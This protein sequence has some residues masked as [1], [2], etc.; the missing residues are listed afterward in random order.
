MLF[1]L[2]SQHFGAFAAEVQDQVAVLSRPFVSGVLADAVERAETS[3]FELS[4]QFLL[5]L[6]V[7]F[8]AQFFAERVTGRNEGGALGVS[9]SHQLCEFRAVQADLHLECW[10]CKDEILRL[11]VGL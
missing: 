6:F 11:H 2:C 7:F 1:V 8:R 10:L 5:P 9:F 3:C 4:L